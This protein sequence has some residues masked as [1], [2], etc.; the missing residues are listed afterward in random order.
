MTASSALLI[1]T[2]TVSNTKPIVKQ[3][4][5]DE[6]EKLARSK[7]KDRTQE[8]EDCSG[9]DKAKSK[10]KTFET[11]LETVST[12]ATP[13]VASVVVT[14]A[15]DL[16]A[17]QISVSLLPAETMNAIDISTE[18][19]IIVPTVAPQMTTADSTTATDDVISAPQLATTEPTTTSAE[20]PVSAASTLSSSDMK[21]LIDALNRTDTLETAGLRVVP[22]EANKVAIQ[23]ALNTDPTLLSKPEAIASL[24]ANL[25]TKPVNGVA[26]GIDIRL[27]KST[28]L[29]LYAMAE[30][31]DAADA[32]LPEA[33]AQIKSET[34]TQS[35]DD[36]TA[37]TT[38]ISFDDVLVS[39]LST[40]GTAPTSSN[41]GLT[42]AGTIASGQHNSTP[43]MTGQ[44]PFVNLPQGAAQ[45][46]AAV[47]DKYVKDEKTGAQSISLRLDPAELGRMDVRME[48]KKGDPL[49]VHLVVEKADTMNMFLRDQQALENALN[50]AGIKSEN[51]SLS[52][53][54]NQ[55]A[56]EHAMN[57]HTSHGKS[58]DRTPSFN[59]T[60]KS[61]LMTEMDQL[62]NG[63]L[64][65][66]VDSH[67]LTRYNARV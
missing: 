48:Y 1:S 15:P 34:T 14:P 2:P 16:M 44:N 62:A 40:N 33:V 6:N 42:I 51:V 60:E 63:H 43:A 59:G 50:Q 46:V 32:D 27:E 19:P 30:T 13:I 12:M 24:M 5:R 41:L 22:S 67:G 65:L 11:E 29:N 53:E 10:D 37:S 8:C 36:N 39:A 66:Y 64:D 52:F 17:S 45:A 7:E 3:D 38:T 4:D 23:N 61:D 54:H 25:Q 57:E 55:G 35:A 58:D 47:I 56:F 49:K 21:R 28:E 18:A 31:A 9:G 20:T 26:K